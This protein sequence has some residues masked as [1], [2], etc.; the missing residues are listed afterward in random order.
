MLE[1]HELG[2][3]AAAWCCVA[4]LA[5]SV[6]ALLR[7][8]PEVPAPTNPPPEWSG[9]HL[10][11]A[12]LVFWLMPALALPL[13]SPDA[14]AR[15]CYGSPV[16]DAVSKSLTLAAASLLT[17][18]LQL[19][20]WYALA[21]SAQV[22]PPARRTMVHWLSDTRSAMK[23]WLALTPI[24]FVVF[25]G[26]VLGY[27]FLFGRPEEHPL[28]APFQGATPLIVVMLL[29][30]EAIIAAPIREELLFRGVL[31]PWMAARDRAGDGG[32]VF[33]ALAVPLVRWLNGAEILPVAA[34]GLAST[35]L[36]ATLWIASRLV[37]ERWISA[38]A[39]P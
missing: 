27:T 31:L 6:W 17:L 13:I 11:A 21:V 23:T 35:A 29:A 4:L 10:A 18:P 39:P 32:M 9:H 22:N 14:L 3:L 2:A 20:A 24:V 37:G 5:A 1:L 25:V 36:A 38:E 7:R 26:S 30:V 34:S 15:W 8:C 16:S 28:L 33:A 19:A 12:F